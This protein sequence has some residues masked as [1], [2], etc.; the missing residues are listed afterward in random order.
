MTAGL[1]RL[2]QALI[3]A[4]SWSSHP[5][6]SGAATVQKSASP[7][8]HCQSMAVTQG[9]HSGQQQATKSGVHHN[10]DVWPL[11]LCSTGSLKQKAMRS[12]KATSEKSQR[13]IFADMKIHP[14]ATSAT[15][16]GCRAEVTD[17]SG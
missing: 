13:C 6:I 9:H 7:F 8:D 3:G 14:E 11:L 15:L 4:T 10:L 16:A 12:P 2:L 1:H 17:S 5:H